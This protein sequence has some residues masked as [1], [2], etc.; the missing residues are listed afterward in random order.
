MSTVDLTLSTRQ[1]SQFIQTLPLDTTEI[2]INSAALNSAFDELIL[3]PASIERIVV[4]SGE[5]RE[6]WSR[7][8]FLGMLHLR[9]NTPASRRKAMEYFA[10]QL[11]L[12]NPEDPIALIHCAQIKYISGQKKEAIEIINSVLHKNPTIILGLQILALWKLWDKATDILSYFQTAQKQMP[13]EDLKQMSV[14]DFSTFV[15]TSED[16]PLPLLQCLI[17]SSLPTEI[18][19]EALHQIHP[20][21]SICFEDFANTPH[22]EEI[23][24][25]PEKSLLQ[26]ADVH[27]YHKGCLFPSLFKPKPLNPNT[28]ELITRIAAVPSAQAKP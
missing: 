9:Q 6:L 1:A 11:I 13:R 27:I 22:Q 19:P 3:L 16:C 25:V 5:T 4:K 14:E 7:L 24:V 17:P 15:I 12:H 18:K 21:C 8:N 28:N 23:A 20:T 26:P 10:E 2:I